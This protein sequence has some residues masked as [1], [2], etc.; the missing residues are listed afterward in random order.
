MQGSKSPSIE[1]P[2]LPRSLFLMIR[3]DLANDINRLDKS[4]KYLKILQKYGFNVLVYD[5]TDIR[6]GYYLI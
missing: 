6:S 4:Y 1:L 5:V 3:R 2:G